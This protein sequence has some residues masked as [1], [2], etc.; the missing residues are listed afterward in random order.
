MHRSDFAAHP[1]ATVEYWF[2]KL[3]VDDLAFL[4]D[5]ILRPR[6]GGGEVRLSLWRRGVG[7]VV[8]LASGD[9]RAGRDEVVVGPNQLRSGASHGAADGIEWDL[10]W[11]VGERVVTPLPGL[12]A[13]AEA[14]DLSIFIRPDCRFNGHVTVDGERFGLSGVPGTFSHYWGRRLPDRWIWLSATSFDDDPDRRVEAIFS[15]TRLW[16]VLPMP[17]PIGL[18]WTRGGGQE[19]LV[20]SPVNG[21]VRARRLG[22]GFQLVARRIG[23]PRHEVVATWGQP[24][25][26]DLGEGIIQT[27]HGDCTVDGAPAAAATVGVETRAW[28]S[29]AGRHPAR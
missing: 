26:N 22:A 13:R 19:D 4:V 12:L 8:H 25:A 6:S 16:G 28:Q 7:R 21:L 15:S 27:L 17:G 11:D 20:V 1:R 9:W 3:H 24:S 18:L 14:L 29:L 10:A 23:G 5:F 2:W